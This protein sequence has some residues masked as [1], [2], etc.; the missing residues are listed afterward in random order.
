MADTLELAEAHD[1]EGLL[2]LVD[3]IGFDENERTWEPIEIMWRDAPGFL[4]T[5]LRE[6]CPS[7][8]V[9]SWLSHQYGTKN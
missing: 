2:F 1:R 6:I 8:R 4:W 9:R 3:W 7:A 5:I